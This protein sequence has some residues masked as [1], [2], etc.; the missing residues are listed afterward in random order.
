MSA[1]DQIKSEI[2]KLSLS[3]RGELV[4]WLHGWQDDAWDAQVR[5]DAADGK[6]DDLLGDVDREIDAGKLR[7]CLEIE[8]DRRFLELLSRLPAGIQTL[9][10][11]KYALWREEPFNPTLHFKELYTD[12][13]SVRIN[14]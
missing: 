13:W 9:A 11:D 7:D 5:R 14:L 4:R 2:E 3:E 10:R 1:V 12:L 6:L 8:S